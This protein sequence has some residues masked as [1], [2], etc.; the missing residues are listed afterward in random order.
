MLEGKLMHH[1]LARR[2]THLIL[3]LSMLLPGL[4]PTP[5][6]AASLYQAGGGTPTPS[7]TPGV[8]ETPSASETPSPISTAEVFTSTQEIPAPT[9]TATVT[10]T[11]IV[12]P[13]VT[14]TITPTPT[15]FPLPADPEPTP[16]ITPTLPLTLSL[17]ADTAYLTPGG[18]AT[19]SW[20]IGGWGNKLGSIWLSVTPPPGFSLLESASG[21]LDPKTGAL[22]LLAET[23]DGYMNWHIPVD[24]P[25]PYVFCASLSLDGK[26]VASQVFSL[27]GNR[28]DPRER[29]WR[30][31]FRIG[32]ARPGRISQRRDG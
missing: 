2:L 13:T 22:S 3:I 7:E 5:T 23:G 26:T 30:C 31:S 24:L 9:A 21:V 14:V 12:T 6:R 19:L 27:R 4:A 11:L 10:P 1:T 25:G 16:I 18:Q 17:S 32:R 8:S 28:P 20:Q 15:P 29:R